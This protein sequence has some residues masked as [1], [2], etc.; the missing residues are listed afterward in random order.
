MDRFKSTTWA[1]PALRGV[2][3]R[4]APLEFGV[5]DMWFNSTVMKIAS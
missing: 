5:G 4:G 3:S 1:K 2:A